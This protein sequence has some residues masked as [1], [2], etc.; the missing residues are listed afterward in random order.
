MLVAVALRPRTE[1]AIAHSLPAS[2][3]RLDGHP[4]IDTL[5]MYED[6]GLLHVCVTLRH[7]A[8]ADKYGF[9]ED[10]VVAVRAEGGV[11]VRRGARHF[12]LWPYVARPPTVASWAA[13][14]SVCDL[15]PVVGATGA[16]PNAPYLTVEVAAHFDAAQWECAW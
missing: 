2:A 8:D 16:I 5:Y 15:L 10:D 6:G 11:H 1:R 3:K 14:R 4:L 13:R 12:V 9:R 7:Q